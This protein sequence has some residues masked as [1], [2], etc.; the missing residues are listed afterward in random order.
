MYTQARPLADWIDCVQSGPALRL[1][2][3]T[4]ST[5]AAGVAPV[6]AE[7]AHSFFRRGSCRQ[8]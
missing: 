1:R 4:L 2:K 5:E 7:G 8:L 6:R 3:H